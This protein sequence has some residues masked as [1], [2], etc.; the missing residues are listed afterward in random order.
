MHNKKGKIM[1]KDDFLQNSL[2]AKE[3]YE[4]LLVSSDTNKGVYNIGIELSN[5]QILLIDQVKDSEVH[6][7]VHMWVPQIQEIQRRYGVEGDLGNY[8]RS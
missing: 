5:N 4:G 7:R 1:S 2:Y 8:S 3:E 6:E